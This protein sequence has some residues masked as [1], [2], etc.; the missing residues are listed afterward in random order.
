MAL[1]LKNVSPWKACYISGKGAFRLT[2]KKKK[3]KKKWKNEMQPPKI[4]YSLG[5]EI[6]DY[7][8][9]KNLISLQMKMKS[10]TYQTRLE[11]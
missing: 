5:N 10:Y 8:I 1:I 2:I 6:L 4:S 11:K 3:K 7:K 9:K